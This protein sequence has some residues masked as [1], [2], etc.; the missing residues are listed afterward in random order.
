MVYNTKKKLEAGDSFER[1]FGSGGHNKTLT[2]EFL[3]SLFAEI[4]EDASILVL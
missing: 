4:E 3:V 2:D 1:K